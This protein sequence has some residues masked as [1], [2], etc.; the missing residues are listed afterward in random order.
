MAELVPADWPNRASSRFLDLPSGRVHVQIAGSGPCVLCVHGTGASTHTWRDV[1]PRLARRYTVVALDLPG[2]GFSAA[3][4]RGG[5]HPRQIAELVADLLGAL[6]LEVDYAIG[7]SAGA[8]VLAQLALSGRADPAAMVF[9]NPALLPLRGLHWPFLRMIARGFADSYWVAPLVSSQARRP[10]AVKRMLAGIGTEISAEAVEQYRFLFSRKAH[11]EG[12]LRMMSEW[13]LSP[14]ERE[15]H[16][17]Q[18]P[19][20]V[21]YGSNDRAVPPGEVNRLRQYL[22]HAVFVALPAGHLAHE[23]QPDRVIALIEEWFEKQ[24]SNPGRVNAAVP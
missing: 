3:P 20:Q 4:A 23:E 13:D 17:L 14:L 7:H 1:I 21:L 8:V 24:H 16:M 9:V 18:Q 11:L 19:V 12:M 10:E 22:E 6:E 2:H 15:L 5:C